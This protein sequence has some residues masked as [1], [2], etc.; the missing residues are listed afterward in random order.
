[1]EITACNGH[2]VIVCFNCLLIEVPFNWLFLHQYMYSPS[3]PLYCGAWVIPACGLVYWRHKRVFTTHI[4][5]V[6]ERVPIPR[7]ENCDVQ[8]YMYVDDGPRFNM[9]C[10]VSFLNAWTRKKKLKKKLRS[11]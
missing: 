2:G 7:K 10:S 3:I 11:N 6:N 1:M 4:G 5:F 9:L 8:A